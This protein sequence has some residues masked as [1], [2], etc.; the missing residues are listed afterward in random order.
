MM[1][2]LGPELVIPGAGAGSPMGSPTGTTVIGKG[3]GMDVMGSLKA[4]SNFATQFVGNPIAREKGG[5]V[6]QGRPVLVG[7]KGPEIVVPT[8]R[9]RQ[10]SDPATSWRARGA[11]GRRRKTL[12]A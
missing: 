7:E 1:G 4:N 5:P 9:R 6:P 12:S 8:S 10:R 3:G 2:E 11:L